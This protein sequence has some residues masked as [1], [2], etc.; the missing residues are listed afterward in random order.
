M[1]FNIE[2]EPLPGLL[3]I[4]VSRYLDNRGWFS[5]TFQKDE[6]AR[7]GLPLEFEQENHSRSVRGVVRG[8]HMQLQPPMGKLIRVVRGSISLVELD[9]RRWSSTYGVHVKIDVSDEN[10][11][12]V[13]VPPGFANGFS[14]LSEFSD[15][16]YRCTTRWNPDTEI[17]INP[18][19]TELAIDWGVKAP[20][21]S[22]RDAR[23]QTFRQLHSEST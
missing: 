10:G 9:V 20:I 13:W 22:E 12:Q 8:L 7:L 16:V 5:E 17:T 23:A 14:V 21:V 1:I 4:G 3:V 2:D 15:V 18:F 11:R 6:F 19:D